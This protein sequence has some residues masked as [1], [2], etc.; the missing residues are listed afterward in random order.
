MKLSPERRKYYLNCFTFNELLIVITVLSILSSLLLPLLL[1][2]RS[3]YKTSFC[4]DSLQRLAKANVLY[5]EDNKRYVPASIGQDFRWHGIRIGKPPSFHFD[6]K[7]GPLA[8]YLKGEEMQRCP[9]LNSMLKDGVPFCLES[10]GW[11]YG[12]NK[13]IGSLRYDFESDNWTNQCEELGIK[14]NQIKKPDKIVMFTDS[15]TKVD[16]SGYTDIQGK[17]SEYAFCES[18]DIINRETPAWGTPDPTIHFRHSGLCNTAWSD[19]HVSKEKMKY[20]KGEWGK[21]K[22]GFIGNRNNENFAPF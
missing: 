10:G 13:N 20:S 17:M 12:Y 11:G 14:K 18:Y 19:G 4:H 8:P 3:V 16:F 21:S 6:S 1:S 7:K 5:T 15:A 2:T 22:L 9:E